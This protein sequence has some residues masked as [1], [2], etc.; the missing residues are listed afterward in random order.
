MRGAAWSPALVNSAPH[1]MQ[2]RGLFVRR[3]A[4]RVAAPHG[5]RRMIRRGFVD[6]DDASLHAPRLRLQSRQGR[7]SPCSAGRT[8]ASRGI[9]SRRASA[10]G[11]PRPTRRASSAFGFW[12]LAL[13]LIGIGVA[14]AHEFTGKGVTVAHPWARATPG[15]VKVGGAYLE[16][17]AAA[18]K[19]DR[20]IG[21]RSPVAGSVELHTHIM[22][23]ASPGCVASTR[24]PS[25]AARRSCCKPGGYHLMLM[26]L[27]QPLKEG[28]LAQAHAGVREGRRDR[29]R[30]HRGADRRDGPARLRSPAW[31]APVSTSISSSPAAP[32]F[33]PSDSA[34]RNRSQLDRRAISGSPLSLR[35]RG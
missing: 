30:S 14:T 27:K 12:S 18:G 2:R 4:C 11:K 17:K 29:G 10:A 24:S 21:A 8:R 5:C 25:P 34:E 9:R 1:L 3:C 6:A 33:P 20:L 28:D 19:G 26:D 31:H 13:L 35:S 16:I 23:R 22:D 7:T 15:G 32:S